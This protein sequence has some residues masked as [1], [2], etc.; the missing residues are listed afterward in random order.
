MS[1]VYSSGS[2]RGLAIEGM[3]EDTLIAQLRFDQLFARTLVIPDTHFLDGTFFVGMTPDDLREIVGRGRHKRRLA[4]E[5]RA[6]K[7]PGGLSGMGLEGALRSLLYRDSNLTLNGFPFNAMSNP[8]DR[9]ALAEILANTKASQLT[10]RLAPTE[11]ENVPRTLCRFLKDL[12][13]SPRSDVDIERMTDGWRNWLDAEALGKL[14]VVEWDRDFSIRRELL[15]RPLSLR[16]FG[17]GDGRLVYRQILKALSEESRHRSDITRIF[18]AARPNF[19]WRKGTNPDND[20]HADAFTQDLWKLDTWY[21]HGRYWAA[22]AQH[23]ASLALTI[24]TDDIA[25]GG[26]EAI[27]LRMGLKRRRVDVELPDEFLTLL[28]QMDGETYGAIA[29]RKNELLKAIWRDGKPSDVRALV[30]DVVQSAD[31]GPSRT[32]RIGDWMK[33]I[34]VVAGSGATAA[35]ATRSHVATLAT[36]GVATAAQ[37]GSATLNSRRRTIARRVVEHLELRRTSA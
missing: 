17:T 24:H 11:R 26:A 35:T 13:A 21:S 10:R 19:A 36:T 23:Q 29:F 32:V 22:A 20:A 12:L 2:Q 9:V 16:E 5:V 8:D 3:L 1:D 15:C 31:E 6:R 28:G 30:Y 33:R 34:A 25:I 14:K 7:G 18:E 37:I 27:L 4:I